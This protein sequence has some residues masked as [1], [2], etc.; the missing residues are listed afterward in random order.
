MNEMPMQLRQKS[1]I[2]NSS[3]YPGFASLL[4]SF[5]AIGL[6]ESSKTIVMDSWLSL[7]RLSLEQKLGISIPK[8]DLPSLK[9]ALASVV[10]AH[11]IQTLLEALVWLHLIPSAH[12]SSLLPPSPPAPIT[13]ADALALYLAHALRYGP[14]ERDLVLL[15]HEIVARDQ[16]SGAE[17]VH[18]STLTAY[19]DARASAMARTVGLP[20]AFAARRVLDGAVRATGV[21]GPTAEEAVWKGVLDGLESRGL[22]VRETVKSGPSMESVLAAGLQQQTLATGSTVTLRRKTRIMPTKRQSCFE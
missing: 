14:H 10:P 12:A 17:Q 9:S 3:R 6:L 4:H 2:N 5:S 7:T 1:D 16:H 8:D 19:G 11:R 15:H 20:V 13:P 18:T 21:C 22:G